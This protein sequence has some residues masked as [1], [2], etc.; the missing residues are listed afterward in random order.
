LPATTLCRRSYIN[1]QRLSFLCV[2]PFFIKHQVKTL[3]ELFIVINETI[4]YSCPSQY[5]LSPSDKELRVE[6]GSSGLEHEYCLSQWFFKRFSTPQS[7]GTAMISFMGAL[8]RLSILHLTYWTCKNFFLSSCLLC[9]NRFI[10]IV[11]SY[12]TKSMTYTS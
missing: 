11:Y 10:F 12:L 4:N 5:S 9:W 8:R 7:L 1:N 2:Y 3:R 6:W